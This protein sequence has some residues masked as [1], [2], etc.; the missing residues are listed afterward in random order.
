MMRRVAG[1]TCRSR[2][3]ESARERRL[4]RAPSAAMTLPSLGDMLAELAEEFGHL[5]D[6]MD[7]GRGC[8]EKL[9]RMERIYEEVI[10]LTRQSR[11]YVRRARN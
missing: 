5:L 3:A 2:L 9:A 1:L 11:A 7:Q 4:F 10:A 8:A 6:E